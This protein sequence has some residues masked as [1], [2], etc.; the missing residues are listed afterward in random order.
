MRNRILALL[1]V[2]L[3]GLLLYGCRRGEGIPPPAPSEP[4]PVRWV[5]FEP[6][7]YIV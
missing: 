1:L 5:R 3:I 4:A 7:E 2:L 6:P